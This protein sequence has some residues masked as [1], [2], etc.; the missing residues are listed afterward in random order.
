MSENP[1]KVTPPA[2]GMIRVRVAVC[3]RSD[4]HYNAVGRGYDD[5]VGHEDRAIVEDSA[6]D[7]LND[8]D[9]AHVVWVEADVPVPAAPLTVEG[10]VTP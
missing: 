1:D 9:V 10:T 2:P 7:W 8:G 4:R 3:V 5:P 6:R